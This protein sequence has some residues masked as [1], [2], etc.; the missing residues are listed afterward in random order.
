MK[1]PDPAD[2]RL[3]IRDIR[4]IKI[5]IPTGLANMTNSKYPEDQRVYLFRWKRDLNAAYR[6][7]LISRHQ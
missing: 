2:V 6:K 1:L 7:I 5:M 4:L 3:T